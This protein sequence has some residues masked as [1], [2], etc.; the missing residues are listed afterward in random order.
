M[1]NTWTTYPKHGDSGGPSGPLAKVPV[2]PDDPEASH[3]V[4]GKA[5]AV[6]ERS[7]SYQFVGRVTAYQGFDGY[8]A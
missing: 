5:P 8:R 3:E 6:W 2:I 1:S 7:M 4:S